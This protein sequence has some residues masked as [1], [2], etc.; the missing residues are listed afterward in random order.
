MFNFQQAMSFI[1][2]AQNPQ[3]IL[4]R[5]G[6]PKECMGSP[7]DTADYLLQS[8]KVSQ[9]QIEQATQMYQQMFK[10]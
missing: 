10:R 6:V 3:Q 8:G 9:Q 4:Q 2:Q 5:M 7:K 1:Q